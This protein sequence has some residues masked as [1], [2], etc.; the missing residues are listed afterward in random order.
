MSSTKPPL[1]P[2]ATR[3]L[4]AFAADRVLKGAKPADI[5]M[6]QPTKTELIINLKT[7]KALGLTIPPLLLLRADQVIE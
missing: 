1:L 2:N 4:A 6:L 7:A 3:D 5:P